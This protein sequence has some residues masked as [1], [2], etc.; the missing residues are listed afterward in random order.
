MQGKKK[1]PP[2]AY[3]HEKGEG[4]KICFKNYINHYEKENT[5]FIGTLKPNHDIRIPIQ[6]PGRQGFRIL[7]SYVLG[8]ILC[9]FYNLDAKVTF[10]TCK[11][12]CSNIVQSYCTSV[13][14][15]HCKVVLV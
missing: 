15:L 2:T 11:R 1:L 12:I 13:Q 8:F 4:S 6:Y 3:L 7:T 5:L 14:N 9:N 10:S